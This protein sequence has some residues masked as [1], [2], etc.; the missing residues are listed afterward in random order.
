VFNTWKTKN[1][2]KILLEP[3]GGW[4]FRINEIITHVWHKTWGRVE[5]RLVGRWRQSS[6]KR[7]WT[8]SAATFCKYDNGD[9]KEEINKSGG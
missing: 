6:R 9:V 7:S 3:S 1:N 4:K 8:M 5:P 2:Y